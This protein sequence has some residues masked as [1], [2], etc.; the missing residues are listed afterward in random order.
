MIKLQIQREHDVRLASQWAFRSVGDGYDFG[1]AGATLRDQTYDLNTLAPAG[2][3][4]HTRVRRNLAEMQQFRRIEQVRRTSQCI[5]SD[6]NRQGCVPTG[7]DSNY[8]CVRGVSHSVS[9][10][11]QS[12]SSGV[13]SEIQRAGD[14]RRLSAYVIK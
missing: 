3:K 9:G 1:L 2:Q 14:L 5:P 6:V 8:Q 11:A 7:S 12:R 4:N 10:R 13:E